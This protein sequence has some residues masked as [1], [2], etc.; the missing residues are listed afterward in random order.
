M[1]ILNILRHPDE[2]LRKISQ[3]VKQ[4]NIAIKYIINDMF[5]TMYKEK[6]IGLAAT[7]V[8]IHQR[9][10]I[11]D[12]SESQNERLVLIN[13]VILTASGKTGI[14]EGCL[15]VPMRR[16]FIPRAKLVKI[17]ALDI[18]GKEFKLEAIG[19]LAICIQHEIDHLNG[20]LFID[21]LSELKYQQ[22]QHKSKNK[23][24]KN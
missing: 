15:S 13:P 21:Y 16:M 20:K 10:I 9:I 5:E 12:I 2:R 4:V 6:G 24:Y 19:L 22:N 8:D 23:F 14:E 7:Q 11:I 18:N 3:P 1:S 17:K